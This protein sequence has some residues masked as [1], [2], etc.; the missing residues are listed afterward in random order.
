M[1]IVRYNKIVAYKIKSRFEIFYERISD[2][3]NIEN[4]LMEM[5]LEKLYQDEIITFSEMEEIRN[6]MITNI[7]KVA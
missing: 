1:K 7:D 3:N 4:S 2:M 6:Q 5:Y